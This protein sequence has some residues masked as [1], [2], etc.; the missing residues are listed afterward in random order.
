MLKKSFFMGLGLAALTS[1]ATISLPASFSQSTAAESQPDKV[2]FFCR[3]I[4]DPA[5]GEQIPATVAWV[6]ERKGHIRFIGWKSEYFSQSGWTPLKRCNKVTQK[7]QEFYEKG[8]L[9]YLSSGKSKGLP[10][11]CGLANQGETCNANNQLFTIKSG[12]NTEQVLQRLTDI[13][14]GKSAEALLQSSGEQLYIPVQDFLN[15]SPLINSK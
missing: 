11:I 7:F 14:E 13:T 8:S 1:V 15:K 9:N 12:S 6:P 4:F 5:S 2:T 10:I 3:Q